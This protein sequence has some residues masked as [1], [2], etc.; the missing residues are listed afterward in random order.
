MKRFSVVLSILAG[1]L[2]LG[3]ALASCDLDLGNGGAS[4]PLSFT[5]TSDGKTVTIIISE[6]DP[7][8]A[9][10]TPKSGNFYEI[11]ANNTRISVGKITISGSKW[12]FTPSN[13]SPGSKT[14]FT[15]TFSNDTLSIASIPGTDI[16]GLKADKDDGNKPNLTGTVTINNTSPTVGAKI[17]ATYSDGNGTGTETWQWFR[18][19]TVISGSDD[20]TYLVV[21]EDAGKTLKAQVSYTKQKGSVTSAATSAVVDNRPAL[22]GK[23]TIDNTLP[24]VDATLTAEYSGGNGT[25]A[26]KWQWLLDGNIIG[27]ATGST[28]TVIAEDAGK[29]LKAQVSYANQKGSVTSDATS[30]VRDDRPDLYGS[31]SIDNTSPTVGEKLT[32]THYGNG[33]GTALWQWLRNDAAIAGATSNTYT[34]VAGDAGKVLKVQVSYANQ[35]GSLTSDDTDVVTA[36]DTRPALTGTVIISGT[37]TVGG[38]LVAGYSGNGTGT[39]TWQWLCNDIAIYGA[40]SGIYN[41]TAREV[42][43][44]LKAQVSWSNQKGSI[45]SAAVS[46]PTPVVKDPKINFKRADSTDTDFVFCLTNTTDDATYKVFK[47]GS[48]IDLNYGPKISLSNKDLESLDTKMVT[49]E[50]INLDVQA[51][52]YGA[53]NTTYESKR[54]AFPAMLKYPSDAK[55]AAAATDWF[56]FVDIGLFALN[57]NDNSAFSP[58]STVYN[59][60]E[61]ILN[62][63]PLSESD[64]QNYLDPTSSNKILTELNDATTTILDK[65]TDIMQWLSSNYNDKAKVF[66]NAFYGLWFNQITNTENDKAMMDFMRTIFAQAFPA[67]GTIE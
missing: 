13:D 47:S 1:L 27:W 52:V 30:E 35:K 3:L 41:V 36:L 54:S 8:R 2:V 66:F 9:V 40:N 17:E 6:T 60:I 64:G 33:T 34:V 29:T 22:T 31:V 55:Y 15:G 62:D 7:S 65:V 20:S 46:V 61:A 24:A 10:L 63:E 59:E 23:V 12:T 19:G 53:F 14:Q 39:A 44:T 32:A 50:W 57:Y 45:T 21:P 18:G 43:A 11:K 67:L 48:S 28:Y 25:G 51:V 49:Y 16:T 4:T 26:A 37:P 42:G 5:G 56:N 58:H 38:K